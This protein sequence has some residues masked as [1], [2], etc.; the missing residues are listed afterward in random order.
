[1]E[2]RSCVEPCLSEMVDPILHD[3]FPFGQTDGPT[4]CNKEFQ[5]RYS[6]VRNY[7]KLLDWNVAVP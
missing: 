5:W 7:E 6:L 3:S 4:S 2:R 1:M